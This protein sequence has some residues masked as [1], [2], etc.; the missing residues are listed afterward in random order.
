MTLAAMFASVKAR[1]DASSPSRNSSMTTREPA[2]P[3]ALPE[4]MSCTASLASSTVRATI[5]PLPAARPSALSTT[6]RPSSRAAGGSVENSTDW[7]MPMH[8]RPTNRMRKVS[9]PGCLAYS[10]VHM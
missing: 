7:P 4:S 1:N 2:A 6:G 5:T 10:P 9:A 8:T 3:K